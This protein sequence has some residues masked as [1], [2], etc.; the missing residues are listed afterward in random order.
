MSE[1]KSLSPQGYIYNRDNPA[2]PFWGTEGG[3]G[4]TGSVTAT[5]SV[6]NNTGVPEVEVTRTQSGLITNFDFAFHNLKGAQGE[7]GKSDDLYVSK[8]GRRRSNL[9]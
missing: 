7:K 2:N 3:G 4:D 8:N 5:A 9:D 6:D 1:E